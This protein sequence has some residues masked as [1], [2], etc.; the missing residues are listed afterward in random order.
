MHWNRIEGTRWLEP[1]YIHPRPGLFGVSHFEQIAI[2]SSPGGIILSPA[3][4]FPLGSPQPS[5]LS[6][7]NAPP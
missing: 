7:C 2:E 3:L 4:P 6:A 5:P 1:Q